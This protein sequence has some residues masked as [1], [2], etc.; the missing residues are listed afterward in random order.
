MKIASAHSIWIPVNAVETAAVTVQKT[1]VAIALK[2]AAANVQN[3]MRAANAPRKR[4]AATAAEIAAATVPKKRAA[5][6][7]LNKKMAANAAAHTTK[8][9][10]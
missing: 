4:A 8:S 6:T 2:K 1:A 7:A 10:L 3:I 9:N 5:V